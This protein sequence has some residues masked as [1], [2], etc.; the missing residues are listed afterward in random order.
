MPINFPCPNCHSTVS[1]PDER[2]GQLAECPSCWNA[3]AVPASA[4][5]RDEIRREM[6]AELKRIRRPDSGQRLFFSMANA[7]IIVLILIPLLIGSIIA[8]Y[9]AI[10]RG[11]DG[12]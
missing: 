12:L 5:L 1:V 11:G 7:L 6:Q 3:V 8:I 9:M 2:A 4:S 10:T